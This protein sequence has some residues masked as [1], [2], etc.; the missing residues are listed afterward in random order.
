MTIP[1]IRIFKTFLE[2]IIGDLISIGHSKNN[3][4]SSFKNY[5]L[6]ESLQYFLNLI[7][8]NESS[9]IQ[10][11]KNSDYL[12]SISLFIINVSNKAEVD[13]RTYTQSSKYIELIKS[14]RIIVA[15]N[16][17]L[18]KILSDNVKQ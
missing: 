12:G 5:D 18:N 3:I 4:S 17:I 16:I 7:S 8:A 11:T 14:L 9:I 2:D 15:A 6:A 13:A 10:S 1:E